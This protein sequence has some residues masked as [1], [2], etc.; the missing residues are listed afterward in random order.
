M[1]CYH[2]SLYLHHF[3]W[4]MCSSTDYPATVRLLCILQ[5][6]SVC[7]SLTTLRIIL[8][9]FQGVG[10]SG[11]Y[12]VIV[13]IFFELVPPSKFALTTSLIS[14]IF[15][16]AFLLGP[17]LGGAITLFSSWRWVFIIKQVFHP[18]VS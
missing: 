8:R 3:F 5:F 12:A 16:L 9:A 6:V 15:A 4:R 11:S 10:A 1:R 18:E 14:A 2:L 17:L 7:G 13:T